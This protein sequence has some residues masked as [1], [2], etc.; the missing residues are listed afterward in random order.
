MP[1]AEGAFA[2]ADCF[3]TQEKMVQWV[4]CL[5]FLLVDDQISAAFFLHFVCP[6]KGP[7]KASIFQI[8]FLL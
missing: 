7:V 6:P 3:V 5:S 1:A 2:L 8:G 4:I